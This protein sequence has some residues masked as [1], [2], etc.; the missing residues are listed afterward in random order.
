VGEAYIVWPDLPFSGGG[1]TTVNL[2]R[3]GRWKSAVYP[4]PVFGQNIFVG[5]V[6]PTGGGEI[7]TN[8]QSPAGS[9]SGGMPVKDQSGVTIYTITDAISVTN[10]TPNHSETYAFSEWDPML[11]DPN[12]DNPPGGGYWE[13]LTVGD[14]VAWQGI[15]ASN[16][17]DIDA[18]VQIPTKPSGTV[19][20]F[21]GSCGYKH[22][23]GASWTIDGLSLGQPAVYVSLHYK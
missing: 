1:A 18:S 8:Y 12:P 5:G 23:I 9:T 7:V 11:P 10:S 4:N 2:G 14:G 3:T 13:T 22:W 17:A 19:L 16:S 15:V 20:P 6:P 21:Y